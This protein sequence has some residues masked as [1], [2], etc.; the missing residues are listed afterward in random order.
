M[1]QY[2]AWSRSFSWLV[3]NPLQ[4]LSYRTNNLWSQSLKGAGKVASGGFCKAKHKA[5]V[6]LL[7]GRASVPVLFLCCIISWWLHL[8]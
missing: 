8:W 2:A 5:R 6:I 4:L 3:F 1:F 7:A